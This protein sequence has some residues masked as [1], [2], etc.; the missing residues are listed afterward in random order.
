MR[1]PQN[2]CAHEIF[3]PMKYSR[4]WN[5]RAHEMC[6]PMKCLRPWN[7]CVHD[8]RDYPKYLRIHKIF[9]PHQECSCLIIY[10]SNKAAVEIFGA[11]K[12]CMPNV[13]VQTLTIWARQNL[14]LL[15]PS[16]SGWRALSQMVLPLLHAVLKWGSALK[17]PSLYG[18]RPVLYRL[19]VPAR[20]A[21]I[22]T[23]CQMFAAA[24]ISTFF[25]GKIKNLTR[26]I[27]V[28]SLPFKFVHNHKSCPNSAAILLSLQIE[29][30]LA[31]GRK[32][33]K[34]HI[35]AMGSAWVEGGGAW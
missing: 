3:A 31:F 26:L 27:S 5:I 10:D 35:S 33:W 7:V 15:T 13:G 14:Q 11:Y 21:W 6:E 18:R 32:P 12:R 2:I 20:P 24:N 8:I 19:V 29:S 9:A 30:V 16:Q 22:F 25:V 17:P 34:S 4:P 28:L 23:P 1:T